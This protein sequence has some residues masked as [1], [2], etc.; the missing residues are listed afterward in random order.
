MREMRWI[1]LAAVVALG[2][3]GCTT[4]T[5]KGAAVGGVSGAVLGA[6]AGAAIGGNKG[7]VIG[8][9][10][11]AATGAAGGAL[12]GRYM[13]KQAA[14]ME[15]KVDNAQIVR[16]GDRLLVNFNSQILFGVDQDDLKHQARQDL[17]EFARVLNDYPDTNVVIQGHTD[18]TGP[19]EYNEELSW[20]RA[21]AVVAFLEDE[22]VRRGRLSAQGL[23]EGEP[24]ASNTTE[25]GRRLNRRVHIEITANETLRRQAA[26]ADRQAASQQRAAVPRQSAR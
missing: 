6:G 19:G 12:I 8:A 13:D 2:V 18:S 26:E 7:A 21:Q 10:V 14:A 23:G 25:E 20:R 5:G 3:S 17:A 4:R 24:A 11:G 15:K 22:G 9:G 1:T 16:Q